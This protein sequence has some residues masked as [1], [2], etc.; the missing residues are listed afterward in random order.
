MRNA[1]LLLSGLALAGAQPASFRTD[2]NLVRLLVNVKNP[3]GE[4]VGSLEKSEFTVYDCGIQQTIAVIERYTV[5]PLSVSILIDISGSTA[6]DLRYEVT[7]IGKFLRALFMEGN[8]RDMAAMY[9]FNYDVTLLSSFTRRQQK[10]E[11]CLRFLKPE[12]GTSLYDA[13]YH[14]ARDLERRDGRHV[15][16]IVS[17]GGNTTSSKKYQD[18]KDA[19]LHADAIMYPIV[20][21]PITND[22]GRNTGGEHALQTLSSDT[23]GRFFYPNVEQLDVAF[24]DILR[25]LRAQYMIGYYPRDL[26]KDAPRFHTVKVETK[27]QDLRAFTRTGYYG[28]ESR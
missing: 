8:P 5:Q 23:G 12:G 24:A 1:L 28:N 27:R 22:A 17:D 13:I 3:A 21:V 19:V 10:L 6:K 15:V 7:S 25:D 16:V 14:A 20:V 18:A 9:S 26:P 2:V 11:E 4:L